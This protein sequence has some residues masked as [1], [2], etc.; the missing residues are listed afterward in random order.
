VAHDIASPS[1]TKKRKVLVSSHT[2]RVPEFVRQLNEWQYLERTLHRLMAAWGRH[3]TEVEDKAALHRHVWEQAEIIRRLRERIDQFPGG[4]PDGAV[5][6]TFEKLANL[7]LFA[8]NFQDA[9]DA[10]Y[11]YLLRALVRV[12]AEHV[13]NAHP[14][15]DAPTIAL[16]HEINTLKEQ[17]YFW[18]RDYRRRNPHATT[19]EYRKTLEN[20]IAELHGFRVPMPAFEGEGAKPCGLDR[21]FLLPQSSGRPRDWR[22]RHDIM[23]YFSAD[24]SDCVESRRLFWAIGYFWEINL[25][26]DQLKWLYYGQRMPWSWHHDISRHLWDESRHGLSGYSRL[27]DWGISLSNVGLP[28]YGDT[29]RRSFPP[30]TPLKQRVLDPFLEEDAVD[31]LAPG[32]PM[33]AADLYEAVFYIGMIAENGH[34]GVKNE[35]Y[36]DFREGKDFESAEM[37]LF[38]IIDETTHVQYAHRWLPL[39]AEH[40]GLDHTGYRERAAKIRGQAQE[41][42]MHRAQEAQSLPRTPGFI[43]WDHYQD[44]LHRI[45]DATPFTPG[46]TPVRRSHKPM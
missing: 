22:S 19:A 30:G 42:E 11:H 25:P 4:K 34:F 39:L 20:E 17:H 14:I 26:D 38:D 41:E 23:P 13:Q 31:F 35:A 28:P 12:Y 6:P 1:D 43:P 46:F 15:H 10:I 29:G 7:A 27:R 32:I 16:L 36:D 8:P 33:S 45:R 3:H 9:L 18:Y 21:E 44:L 40:A 5:H 24:F 37:M 2:R